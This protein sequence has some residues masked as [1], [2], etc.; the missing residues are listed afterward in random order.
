[1]LH[2]CLA[3]FW[4]KAIFLAFA[5]LRAIFFMSAFFLTRRD[6][7]PVLL[8]LSQTEWYSSRHRAIFFLSPFFLTQSDLLTVCFF[9]TQRGLLPVCFLSDT[10]WS[11]S[12]LLLYTEWSSSRLLL[13]DTEWS[14][15]LPSFWHRVIFFLSAFFL[16]QS[17]LLPVC[18]L[19][20]TEWS[21]SCLP[22]SW[23]RVIFF[24][25]SF[26]S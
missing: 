12:R 20:D 13:P 14:S 4:H 23:H 17:D 26:S 6:L 3:S 8:L 15:C 1:M 25:S 22:S 18:L 2:S 24:L 7:F 19:P 5:F 21:S 16:T 9:Q 10:E 11:S